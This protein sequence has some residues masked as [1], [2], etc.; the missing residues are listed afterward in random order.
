M[1]MNSDQMGTCPSIGDRT[2]QRKVVQALLFDHDFAEQMS[3]VIRYEFFKEIYLSEIVK[4]YFSYKERFNAFPSLEVLDDITNRACDKSEIDHVTRDGI[5]LYIKEIAEHPLNGDMGYIQENS[6][7]FCRR[8]SLLEGVNVALGEIENNNFDSVWKIITDAATKG[9]TRDLGHNYMGNLDQRCEK[10]IRDP[11]PTPWPVLNGVFGGGA[12]RGGLITFIGP[13][14]GGKTHFLCNIS[15]DG[16]RRGYNV[17]YFTLEMADFKIGLRHDAYFS[18]I[19]I[20]GIPNERERVQQEIDAAVQKDGK[21]F[22]KE[23]PT[24]G[25]SVTTIRSY[26]QR[27]KSITG[28]SPDLIV[29]DYAALL[30]A[31]RIGDKAYHDLETVYGELRG[32]AK[33]YNSVMYTG[34]QTNRGGL[35]QEIVT[36]EQIADAYNRATVC[37]AI[38]TISR[39]LEDKKNGTGRVFIAKSR[40]GPDG[41]VYPFKIDPAV[42]KVDILAEAETIEDAFGQDQQTEQERLRRRYEEL[43]GGKKNG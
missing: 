43:T 15:G 20:N 13:T 31:V 5:N 30:K 34:D 40:F 29:L 11:V 42:V 17:V 39:T 7:D 36:L 14:G 16:L 10:S 4:M 6:L 3:D 37:D 12:D 33:E 19:R 18:G 27:M 8:Q 35:N 28:I 32:V 38:I 24:K 25:A 22:I 2:Y 23:Y 1:V 26:L 21:L 41:F 9:A